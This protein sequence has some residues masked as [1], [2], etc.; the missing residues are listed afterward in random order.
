MRVALAVGPVRA[1]QDPFDGE[2][3]GELVD[4]LLD[5]G[6]DPAVLDELIPRVAS[7]VA[8]MT[9]VLERLEHGRYPRGAVLDVGDLQAWEPL[10]EVVRHEDVGE[11]VDDA[12]LHER[13]DDRPPTVHAHVV[14][15]DVDSQC[16][17]VAPHTGEHR[18]QLGV[19]RISTIVRRDH[20]ARLL[21]ELPEWIEHR[22]RRRTEPV[23]GHR[24]AVA[25]GDH[26]GAAI[27]TPFELAGHLGGIGQDEVRDRE[28]PVLVGEP[29]P[30]LQPAVEGPV[31]LQRGVHVV[32]QE[33]LEHDTL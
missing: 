17:R 10:E 25:D 26:A 15:R 18:S 23:G 4:A 16:G 29:P 21:C 8:A 28:D 6:R 27:E 1:E 14:R 9:Q 3:P 24:R 11:V 31:G 19:G 2:V 7:V 12:V 13:A 20:D 5:E 32:V 22:I 30:L 33:R